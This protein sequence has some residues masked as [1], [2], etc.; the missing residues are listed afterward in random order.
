MPLIQGD[1]DSSKLKVGIAVS[2]LHDGAVLQVG[3]SIHTNQ[4]SDY[5]YSLGSFTYKFKNLFLNDSVFFGDNNY[6]RY[7]SLSDSF[8]ITG[9]AN[10]E[11]DLDTTGGLHLAK[12]LVVDENLTLAGNIT[13]SGLSTLNNGISFSGDI[14]PQ[15]SLSSKLGDNEY[16]FLSANFHNLTV[17][18]SSKFNK[19]EAI[20]QSHYLHKTIYLASK[21]YIDT[22][23]GGGVRSL[24][25]NYHPEDNIEPPVGYLNDEEL[26][27]AGLNIY[28]SD[29]AAGYSRDYY[30]QF[31]PQDHS[32]KHPAA[33]NA[34]TRSSWYSNISLTTANGCH[35]KTDR[36]LSSDTVAMLNDRTGIGVFLRDRYFNSDA[37]AVGI[38]YAN[39]APT[40]SICFG[41]EDSIKLLYEEGDGVSILP[42]VSGY[43]DVEFIA[44][45]APNNSDYDIRYLASKNTS[46]RINQHFDIL[47]TGKFTLSY[48]AVDSV[49]DNVLNPEAGQTYDRFIIHGE[50]EGSNRTFMI[51]NHGNDGTVGI[52]DFTNGQYLTPDTILN[53]RA[54]GDAILRVTAE[55][56]ASTKS[57]LQLLTQSNCLDYG[58][59]MFY[60]NSTDEFSLD[61][62]YNGE[63]S[64]TNVL[65][66]TTSSTNK[67]GVYAVE[68][69]AM[70]TL[71]SPSDTQAAIS[72]CENSALAGSNEGYG[73]IFVRPVDRDSQSNVI[74]FVDSSGNYFELPMNAIV[75][76]GGAGTLVDIT[77]YADGNKNT[78]LGTE[79]PAA[80]SAIST[81]NDNVTMGYRAF[82]NISTGD[83][84]TFIG[85]QAGLFANGS[86]ESN[87]CI[88]YKS[89]S[90]ANLGSNNIII[91]NDITEGDFSSSA[92]SNILIDDV[93]EVNKDMTTTYGTCN[94]V[95]LKDSSLTLTDS[96]AFLNSINKLELQPYFGSLDYIPHSSN[97]NVDFDIDVNGNTVATFKSGSTPVLEAKG[98]VK[99]AGSIELGESTISES[100]WNAV[101]SETTE[102]TS[103]S[104]SNS[105]SI[106]AQRN[107]LDALD[108]TLN[109]LY[110]EGFADGQINVATS[111]SNPSTGRIT[112]KVKN[113]NGSWADS[114][115]V[116]ITNRDPYLRI[117]KDDFVVA[118]NINGEYRPIF[119][120]I[121]F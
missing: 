118:I 58:I 8:D 104:Q 67:L 77:A 110:V 44:P 100:F 74:N 63:A 20:E 84:N 13:A 114:D 117:E 39:H 81:A 80:R 95:Y 105:N 101:V 24:Q 106:A 37:P 38:G 93:I 47:D 89:G 46:K 50:K 16:P 64:R 10:F 75:A 96:T 72:I 111:P 65:K 62:Y 4:S 61:M 14:I 119:V 70:F 34:F 102:N 121:P 11:G 71:G 57:S 69:N 19:F 76:D 116:V 108:T 87:I 9:A 40:Y 48:W 27:G 1:L 28:S 7:N 66:A 32:I 23:D 52:N 83:H 112:R 5:T 15:T 78:L 91:G 25:E 107:E 29:S 113:A 103:R 2:E 45:Y 97:P 22:L 6:I 41:D 90:A 73:K 115:S 94:K 31:R 56:S 18:G 54:T 42:A 3:G 85:S 26:V 55:N 98:N 86:V 36:I 99:V 92:S 82:R 109:N 21:G 33:D 79:S 12:S 53:V 43:K 68:P 30:L 120:S 88:G 59:D 35:V 60:D 51:M 17:T 49:D